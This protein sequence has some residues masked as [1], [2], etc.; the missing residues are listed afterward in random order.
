MLVYGQYT[1]GNYTL[2]NPLISEEELMS[3]SFHEYT[4]YSLT[5]KSTI[6]L[7]LYCFETLFIPPDC[8]KD[9]TAYDAI[10][11]FLNKHTQKVQE[12]LAVFVECVI[13]LTS[14]GA[15]A[16]N[17]FINN[18]R[19]NNR[20]YYGYLE[21]L[22]FVI[23]LMKKDAD[24]EE[25]LE[26]AHVVFLSAIEAMNA[27]LYQVPANHFITNNQIKKVM[28]TADFSKNYLPDTRFKNMIKLCKTASTCAEI[29]EILILGLSDNV[30][31]P[32]LEGDK[33]RLEKV[34]EFILDLYKDSDHIEMYKNK[35]S[36]VNVSET[37]FREMYLQQLPTAFNEDMIVNGCKRVDLAQISDLCKES[38]SML[39]LLGSVERNITDLCKYMGFELRDGSFDEYKNK[40]VVAFFG[41]R[42]REIKMT[43]AGEQE[44]DSLIMSDECKSVIVTSYKN[45]DYEYDCINNHPNHEGLVCIYC[46]RTY[47]NA[48]EYLN[49][50]NDREVFYRYMEYRNMSVLIVKI[51]KNRLFLLP[52]TEIVMYEADYDIKNNR[53][54]FKLAC[55]ESELGFDR[56]VITSM[57]ICDA[58]DTVVN[59]L[60]FIFGV[61]L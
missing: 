25:I 15:E 30:M 49:L 44:I 12:G 34:K 39:F 58:I 43:F 17:A 10:T 4:H 41:L 18:L 54:N 20:V 28:S 13:H 37:D 6:G 45:Y 32:T 56:K 23:N 24:R 21:P 38:T 19:V 57:S 31:I 26:T 35:L 40:E 29:R 22:L 47:S 5:V 8:R 53:R 27:E 14:E 11:G 46:D 3:T 7:M 2:L 55:D 42:N 51:A 59:S 36:Q 16:C 60:Y 1:Y 50:W 52:M 61:S 48:Y 9:K 33:H